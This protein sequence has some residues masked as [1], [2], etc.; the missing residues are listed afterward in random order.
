[1]RISRI[2]F[3]L[4]AIGALAAQP[5]KANV[6]GQ[7]LGTGNPPATLGGYTMNP[8]DPGTIAGQN[9]TAYE[10]N[11]NG[12]STGWATWGQS[13]TGPVHVSF[14]ADPLT[15]TLNGTHAIYFY[16]EPNTFSDFIMTALD[17][18]GVS[19][20]TLVNGYHGSSAVG[21]YET[22][23]AQSLTSITVSC[24]DVTGFAI[25]EFGIDTGSVRGVIGPASSPVPEPSTVLLLGAGIAG[26]GLFGR[27][28]S[29]KS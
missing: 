2:L 28:K 27:R 7:N 5:V 20:T 3:V 15:L 4:A 1:M 11:G 10:T 6:I 14:A 26:L 9:Y 8:Y 18:S 17:S 23:P 22:N 13:Y 16:E 24:S 25:G 29:H 19:V 12:N 21:F